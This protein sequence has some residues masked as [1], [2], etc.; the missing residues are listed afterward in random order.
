MRVA[1]GRI[2]ELSLVYGSRTTDTR[3]NVVSH[4]SSGRAS[5]PSGTSVRPAGGFVATGQGR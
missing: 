1:V 3:W 5:A 4:S 2:H